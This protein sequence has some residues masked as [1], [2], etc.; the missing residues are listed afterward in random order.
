[1]GNGLH[2][3]IKTNLPLTETSYHVPFCMFTL[4]WCKF[5]MKLAIT[6]CKVQ[7]K[8]Q[9]MLHITLVKVNWV[10]RRITNFCLVKWSTLDRPQIIVGICKTPVFACQEKHAREI[11][12]AHLWFDLDDL[13]LINDL[14]KETKLTFWVTR[15]HI[16]HCLKKCGLH[17]R[18]CIILFTLFNLQALPFIFY[19]HIIRFNTNLPYIMKIVHMIF[20]HPPWF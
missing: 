1:M 5:N 2:V 11:N 9:N 12:K 10:Y 6:K 15:W 13:R 16:T 20:D 7:H 14:C 8:G 3:A 4:V 18:V 19:H 17:F